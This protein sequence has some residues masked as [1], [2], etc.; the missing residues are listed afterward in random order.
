MTTAAASPAPVNCR[1]TTAVLRHHPAAQH[2]PARTVELLQRQ[3]EARLPAARSSQSGP[4]PTP[5]AHLGQQV[6]PHVAP[7]AVEHDAAG[8]RH[9]W[10]EG[11]VAGV[12]S[13]CVRGGGGACISSQQV[14]AS[15]QVR[16]CVPPATLGT[17]TWLPPAEHALHP[18]QP[19]PAARAASVAP[20]CGQCC[21]QGDA[22]RQR[23]HGAQPRGLQDGAVEGQVE[24]EAQQ[25]L[26]GVGQGGWHRL[27]CEQAGTQAGRVLCGCGQ[28][29][30]GGCCPCCSPH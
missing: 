1:S 26:Q 28:G 12:G 23:G 11:G 13:S 22:R 10:V 16:A 3:R 27:M 24:Q 9:R 15:Q 4:S 29:G 2:R 20:T 21:V 14:L 19:S 17:H 18:V 7:R 8:N 30:E 6:L 5:S 25:C